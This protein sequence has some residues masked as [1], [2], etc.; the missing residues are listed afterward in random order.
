MWVIV[1][2]RDVLLLEIERTS[3]KRNN[4]AS[5]GEEE[6]KRR[7]EGRKL[8]EIYSLGKSSRAEDKAMAG[9][10]TSGLTKSRKGK[11]DVESTRHAQATQSVRKTVIYIPEET[12][13]VSDRRAKFQVTFPSDISERRYKDS[14]FVSLWGKL[15]I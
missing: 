3:E 14:H 9:V 13:N 10:P 6:K 2:E 7:R 15:C 5:K 4:E 1:A 8:V 11:I 12:P